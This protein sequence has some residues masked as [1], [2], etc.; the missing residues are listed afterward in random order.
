MLAQTSQGLEEA[1][2]WKSVLHKDP[3]RKVRDFLYGIW[4]IP[5][6]ALLGERVEQGARYATERKTVLNQA[7]PRGNADTTRIAPRRRELSWA[8]GLQ[9][10]RKTT[11]GQNR[12]RTGYTYRKRIAESA[13]L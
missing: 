3:T 9:N 8:G 13:L 7:N 2:L 6:M 1:I 4:G 11:G 10:S 5:G 12:P